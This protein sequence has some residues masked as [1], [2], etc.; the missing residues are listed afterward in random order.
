MKGIGVNGQTG[1]SMV[2]NRHNGDD[3]QRLMDRVRELEASLQQKTAEMFELEA[4]QITAVAEATQVGKV[5]EEE[6]VGKVRVKE[7]IIIF[8][9]TCRLL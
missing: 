9:P 1:Y 2:V 4:C 6:L 3:L 8:S 7:I 5:R